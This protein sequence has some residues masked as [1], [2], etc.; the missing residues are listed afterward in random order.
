VTTSNAFLAMRLQGP[1][2]KPGRIKLDDFLRVGQE[3]M[4]AVERVGLVLQG[5]AD[6][7]RAG[8]R[9]QDLRAAIS[10]DVVEV[11]HGSPAAVVRFERSQR[12]LTIPEAD[13]G[14]EAFET[15]LK[16]LN[17]VT[18]NSEGLPAGFD[19]G[20]ML[21]VRDAGR[22]FDR[23]IDRIDFTL[24]HGGQPLRA[25]YDRDG[26]NKIQARIVGPQHNQRTF[27]GRLVM[28]D[29]KERGARFRVHPSSGE[30]VVCLF[31]ESLRDE[32]FRSILRFV[33]VTG[34]A[35]V[36]SASNRIV[37]IR[38]SDIERI[39]TREDE[40]R[41][42]LPTGAPLP[43]DFWQALSFA[44]LAAA[45]GVRPIVDLDRLVGCWPGDVNDGFEESIHKLR[46]TN[47]RAS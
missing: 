7:Q 1:D 36:D 31:D 46:R 38:I 25:R 22:V 28:A 12:Q 15:F 47:L 3:V 2:V 29:F 11:T 35:T 10:L 37:S 26:Y 19:V 43:G 34:Q 23:G 13:V 17:A 14:T 42:V 18:S 21:A 24:N 39:E 8:R 27:E 41:D 5:S 9:P 16:G 30:P 45:Q 4:R 33:R 6:S 20:V 44:E 40:V 32:V